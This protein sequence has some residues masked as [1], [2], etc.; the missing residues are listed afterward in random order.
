MKDEEKTRQQLVEELDDLRRRVADLEALIEVKP[1]MD[2]L[3]ESQKKTGRKADESSYWTIFEQVPV[4]IYRTTPDD[5][6]IMAN[7]AL[8]IMLGY[9][10]TSELLMTYVSDLY[11]DIEDRFNH[12]QKLIKTGTYFAEFRLRRK[13]GQLIWVR[14]YPRAVFDPGGKVAFFDGVLVD[15]TEQKQIEQILLSRLVI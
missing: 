6:I 14:D 8:A 1:S 13:D 10:S 7:K 15:I 5:R 3:V 9:E 11:V 2:T 4:G 12:L